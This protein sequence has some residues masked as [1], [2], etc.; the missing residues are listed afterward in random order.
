MGLHRD[1]A[2]WGPQQYLPPPPGDQETAAAGHRE[3]KE[4]REGEMGT[5]VCCPLSDHV[6]PVLHRPHHVTM[7]TG[8]WSLMALVL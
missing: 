1:H 4:R 8:Q 3:W 5:L 7:G 6:V 2:Q